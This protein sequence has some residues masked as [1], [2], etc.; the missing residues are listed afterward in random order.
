MK[1]EEKTEEKDNLEVLGV[2]EIGYLLVPS[3]PEEK[4]AEEA[5][6]VRGQVEKEG[7]LLIMEDIPKMRPLAYSISKIIDSKRERFNQAYFGWVKFEISCSKIS[8]LEKEIENNPHIIRL[9]CVKTVKE[10]TLASIK[11]SLI[12]KTD[13]P[14]KKREISEE[15]LEKSIKKIVGEGTSSQ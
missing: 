14:K 9:I 8:L 11:P 10:S 3:I 6:S 12:K 15:E 7:G 13:S 1:K 2:Y 4:I 5:A